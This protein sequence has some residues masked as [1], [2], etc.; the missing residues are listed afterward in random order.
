MFYFLFKFN[1]ISY[2]SFLRLSVLSLV[3]YFTL[4]QFLYLWQTQILIIKL[5]TYLYNRLSS[6]YILYPLHTHRCRAFDKIN[7]QILLDKLI[8]FELWKLL[9]PLWKLA[10]QVGPVSVGIGKEHSESYMITS[11]VLQGSDI[12]PLFSM[13]MNYLLKY[14]S[15]NSQ[16]LMFADEVFQNGIFSIRLQ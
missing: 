16:C 3:W 8:Q 6:L 10:F 15:S 4:V 1:K 7:H 12:S 14:I 11:G 13:F 2:C 5:E 9:L